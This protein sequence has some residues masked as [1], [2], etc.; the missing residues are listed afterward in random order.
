MIGH[1]AA[2]YDFV[3]F[4]EVSRVIVC[5]LRAICDFSICLKRLSFCLD[6]LYVWIRP[7]KTEIEQVRVQCNRKLCSYYVIFLIITSFPHLLDYVIYSVITS[8]PLSQ[9]VVTQKLSELFHLR[10]SSLPLWEPHDQIWSS[11]FLVYCHKS[12]HKIYCTLLEFY[13]RYT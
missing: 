7:T 1:K 4:P 13:W 10:I 5:K 12:S 8:F 9:F 11:S 3:Y 6:D 2:F